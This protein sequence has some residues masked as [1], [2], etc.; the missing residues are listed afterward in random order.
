MALLR[1]FWIT[2]SL[3]RF[4]LRSRTM[5]CRPYLSPHRIG[6]VARPEYC[7]SATVYSS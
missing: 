1:W 7:G 2:E 6:I 5:F 3:M 4:T